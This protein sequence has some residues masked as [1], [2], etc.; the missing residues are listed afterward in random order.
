MSNKPP[1][2]PPPSAPHAAPAAPAAQ[3]T[4]ATPAANAVPVPKA[5]QV[6]AGATMYSGQPSQLPT[7]QVPAQVTGTGH[8]PNDK[9]SMIA[10]GVN[11][12]GNA[13][14]IGL[15]S[16]GGKVEGNLVQSMGQSITVIVAETGYVKGDIVADNISV[17]GQTDGLLDAGG[18]S[19]ALHDAS[20]VSGHVRYN[21]LQVNGADL[22][23]TLEKAAT[24]RDRTAGAGASHAPA[25]H[26]AIAAPTAA[27]PP[28]ATH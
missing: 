8:E 14:L 9:S 19:V 13:Q 23:A 10:E 7:L 28:K 2:I 16:V 4:P 17:M 18:G 24:K 1:Y 5:M 12:V 3:T 27:N 11:F 20:R 15:C 26:A 22:N 21:R 6:Q 25:P